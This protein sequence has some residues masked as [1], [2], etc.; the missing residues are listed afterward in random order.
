LLFCQINQMEIRVDTK[1]PGQ[2]HH[3]VITGI[4]NGEGMIEECYRSVVAQTYK[5]FEWLIEDDH[6][7]D[8]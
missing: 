2:C 6:S 4:F 3:R 1:K 8:K 5:N 7:T